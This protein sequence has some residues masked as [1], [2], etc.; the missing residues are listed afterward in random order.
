MRNKAKALRR[1]TAHEIK[2]DYEDFMD[3]CMQEVGDEEMCQIFWEEGS[4]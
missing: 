3:E 2:S 4:E 1:G